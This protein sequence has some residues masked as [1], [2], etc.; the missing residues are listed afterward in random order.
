MSNIA[1]A[2]IHEAE[3][4]VSSFF[5]DLTTLSDR[6]RERAFTIFESRGAVPGMALDDWLQAERDL[7]LGTESDLTE[8]DAAFQ[9]R[10]TVPGFTG[11][12]LKVTALPDALVVLAKS[13]SREDEKTLY[14]R[15][16]LPAPIDVDKVT[17]QF[18]KGTLRL[19][20][21]KAENAKA[22]VG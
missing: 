22:A 5:A 8:K 6:I 15:V 14:Q 19:T 10:M 21:A 1:V 20:A 13:A 4:E 18:D 9:L 12:E 2:K 7:T 16:D 17:A 3:R 11:K